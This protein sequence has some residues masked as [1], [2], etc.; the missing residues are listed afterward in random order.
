MDLAIKNVGMS[1]LGQCNVET[2]LRPCS[3]GLS[4]SKVPGFEGGL[5]QKLFKGYIFCFLSHLVGG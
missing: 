2:V 1:F 4:C 3:Q 5:F